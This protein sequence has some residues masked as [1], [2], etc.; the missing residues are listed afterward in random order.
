MPWEVQRGDE[1]QPPRAWVIAASTPD[2]QAFDCRFSRAVADVLSQAADGQLGIDDGVEFLPWALVRRRINDQVTKQAGAGSPQ[3]VTS[4]LL[5]DDV[6]PPFFRNPYYHPLEALDRARAA[7][8]AAV[9][10]FVDSVEV[11]QLGAGATYD[12]GL[13]YEHFRDRAAGRRPI[14][15]A[16]AGLFRGRDEELRQLS[17]WL[18][19]PVGPDTLRIVT[20]SPGSGKSAL[21]GVVVCA[22]LPRL[23]SETAPLW[24]HLPTVPTAN[25][26]A[27]AIHARARGLSDVVASIARQLGLVEPEPGWTPAELIAAVAALPQPPTVI[28]DALDEADHPGALT[29]VLLMPLHE[30]VDRT[31]L[32]S[33][34]SSSAPAPA[35]C[36]RRSDRC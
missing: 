5:D 3:R 13:D 12:Q 2:R 29:S 32:R 34:D 25:H 14:V 11:Q 24:L 10:P 18:D 22:S 27:V 19:R 21:L 1:E 7:A 36:G 16:H 17:D 15:A 31:A 20:G 33:V 4:T 23:R 35:S 6:D 26:M 9:T 30:L 8:P 28:L